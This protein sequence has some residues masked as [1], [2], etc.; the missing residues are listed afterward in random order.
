MFNIFQTLAL[1]CM[2]MTSKLTSPEES[3]TS[4]PCL[5]VS[6]NVRE[7]QSAKHLLMPPGKLK[8]GSTEELVG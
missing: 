2:H 4:I 6:K 3:I 7:N 1:M 5:T 8:I